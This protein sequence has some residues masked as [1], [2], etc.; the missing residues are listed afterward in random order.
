MS[1]YIALS[2]LLSAS[3]DLGG[4]VGERHYKVMVLG[5][6]GRSIRVEVVF[7]RTFVVKGK[8]TC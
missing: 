6:M 8:D 5:S 2:S 4:V 1:G 7:G 3:G